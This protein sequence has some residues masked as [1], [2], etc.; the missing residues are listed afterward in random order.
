MRVVIIILVVTAFFAVAAADRAEAHEIYGTIAAD[1]SCTSPAY[2]YEP[3]CGL[4]AHPEL[5]YGQ[6]AIVSDNSASATS[7]TDNSGT[8]VLASYYGY[9]LAGSP[10]ASGEPFDPEGLTAA[11]KTLPLGTALE[12]C[13]AGSCV[14]VLVNDR[15]PYIPGRELDL[16]QGA[17]EAIG[18]D[19]VGVGYVTMRVL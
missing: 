8:T 3:T 13:Y 15:G 14:E 4:Q 5:F 18:F 19:A 11:H 17:A 7:Q 12:V 10:T 1:G 6:E 9:E 16:S 2:G